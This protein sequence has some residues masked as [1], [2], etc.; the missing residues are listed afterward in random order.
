MRYHVMRAGVAE[1]IT[2]TG[3]SYGFGRTSERRFEVSLDYVTLRLVSDG[4]LDL[5]CPFF[6]DAG[7]NIRWIWKHFIFLHWTSLRL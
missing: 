3:L 4:T 7:I 5:F 6:Q 1:N 2:W